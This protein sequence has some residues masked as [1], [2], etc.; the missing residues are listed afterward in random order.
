MMAALQTAFFVHKVLV[1]REHSIDDFAAGV[2][3][4]ARKASDNVG[5]L[6]G[7]C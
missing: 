2:L 3:A 6:Q 5:C 4:N 7:Y 1:N